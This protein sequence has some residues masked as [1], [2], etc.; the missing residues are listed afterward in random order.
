LNDTS[1]GASPALT[2]PSPSAFGPLR[3]PLFRSMFI[4]MTIANFGAWMQDTGAAWLMTT[5]SDSKLMVALIQ[6]ATT[7][8]FF[9][10]AFPAGALADIIDRRR[11]LLIMYGWMLAASL[12][13][14][15][16]TFTGHTTAWTLLAL[17]FALG[18]G[19]AMM[20]PAWAACVPG[21]VPKEQ[22]REAVA[23][24][25]MSMNAS[26]AIGPAIAGGLIVAAGPALVFLLNALSFTAVVIALCRWRVEPHR[27]SGALPVER[28]VEAM[29]AGVRY[30][31]HTPSLYAVVVRGLAF[32]VF[33]SASWALL[34]AVA[35][36]QLEVGP[37][38]YGMLMASIGLGAIIGAM[39]LPRLHLLMSRDAM[40]VAGT[41]LFALT[42]LGLA[43]THHLGLLLLVMVLNGCGWI[44]VF[45]SL[46]VASQLAVPNWV[47][48]RGIALAMLSFGGGAAVGSA[49]WGYASDHWDIPIA[50]T[51]AG[52][53]LLL[54]IPVT[55]PF[56]IRNDDHVD[57][58]PSMQWPIPEVADDIPPDQGPV[59]V[60]AEFIV[61]PER[62]GEFL[63][64]VEGL[65]RI[66]RRDGAFFWEVFKDVANPRRYVEVFMVE[67]WLEHLRQH[68]RVTVSDQAINDRLK[69]FHNPQA[70][71]RVSHFVSGRGSE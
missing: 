28:F 53:G 26:R 58:T 50:L 51:A 8:P 37:S 13:L 44:A 42:T 45:S 27:E 63:E 2:G 57:L 38:T 20:R 11:L 12:T 35:A 54:Q 36:H 40:I 64:L 29:K 55:R 69:E 17:T 67:S 39:A 25:A 1:S 15:V 7:L 22:L 48:A 49:L 47:R 62:E 56:P 59:L 33:A 60:T 34:P 31:R 18:I 14:A 46:V 41:V 4:A 3:G 52:I 9:L 6:T 5:L 71:P 43:W 32:F 61:P 16:I 21:F 66:R 30:A 19:N 23:L 70:K 68:V 10:L 24:N 65:R